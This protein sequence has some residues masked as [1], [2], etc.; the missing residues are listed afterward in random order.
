MTCMPLIRRAYE[1]DCEHIYHKARCGWGRV[2]SEKQKEGCAGGEGG[3]TS[4]YCVIRQS[5]H[6]AASRGGCDARSPCAAVR[7]SVSDSVYL[8]CEHM[9]CKAVKCPISQN[10]YTK[11]QRPKRR[12]YGSILRYLL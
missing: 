9:S 5:A 11:A 4:V 10:V 6:V 12:F 1:A 3:C 7:V 8:C 2:V